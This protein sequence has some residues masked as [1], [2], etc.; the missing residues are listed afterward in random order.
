MAVIPFSRQTK[1]AGEPSSEKASSD[2][3][4]SDERLLALFDREA[5]RAWDLFLDRYAGL[6][7]STLRHLGFDHDE[8]MDRFVY[9]CEKLCEHDFRRL[10]GIR[11]VG[12]E[13]ELVPWVRT[14]VRNLS[15]SWAWSVDGRRRLFRSIA[16][17]PDR[18]RRVFELYFWRGLTPSETRE[19]L[20]VEEQRSVGLIEVLDALEVLFTHLSD[21]QRWR[22][23]SQLQRHRTPLPIAVDDPAG[24]MAYEPPDPAADPEQT[25]LHEERRRVMVGALGGLESRERLILQLRYEEALTLAEVAEIVGLS[26]AAVKRSLRA[27]LDQLRRVIGGVENGAGGTPCPV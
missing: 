22:L 11:F 15:V 17:L 8:A 27:S 19:H 16:A 6:V 23:M 25:A 14:V 4:L 2:T 10:R 7:L 5:V 26:L 13:G 1:A 18:E 24:P 3:V 12:R 9:I 21:N 20:A